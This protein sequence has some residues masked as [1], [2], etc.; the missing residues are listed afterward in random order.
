MVSS[1]VNNTV[2]ATS[3]HFL[4]YLRLACLISPAFERMT[5]PTVRKKT[6]MMRKTIVA[7]SRLGTGL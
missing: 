2:Q 4:S 1:T 7:L 5:P 6:A 3:E